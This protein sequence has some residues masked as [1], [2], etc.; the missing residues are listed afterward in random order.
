MS[1]LLARARSWG[2]FSDAHQCLHWRS[3]MNRMRILLLCAT[4]HITADDGHRELVATVLSTLMKLGTVR[5]LVIGVFVQ[6]SY[7]D[8]YTIVMTFMSSMASCSE[9]AGDNEYNRHDGHDDAHGDALDVDQATTIYV[10]HL[11]WTALSPLVCSISLQIDLQYLVPS[12]S[13]RV[14]M[15]ITTP[16]IIWSVY[17]YPFNVAI[18]ICQIS[19]LSQQRYLPPLD[20]DG[21]DE[22]V[23]DKN[24]KGKSLMGPMATQM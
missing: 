11:I 15:H 2:T 21:D 8:P 18:F 13:C 17:I 9:C 12:I 1:L 19:S 16:R 3:S 23:E 24:D 5:Q 20:D 10:I 14:Y 6:C 7:R 22:F 4:V